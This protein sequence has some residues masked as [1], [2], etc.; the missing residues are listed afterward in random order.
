MASNRS[1]DWVDRAKELPIRFAQVREDPALDMQVARKAGREISVLLVASGG[2]T[3]CALATL[4]EV[5]ELTVVD[6]N[7]AQIALT[8]IK[9]QLLRECSKLERMQLL[10]HA[11]MNFVEREE[12][13]AQ[14]LDSQDLDLIGPTKNVARMGLDFTGRYEAV[15]REIASGME[16]VGDEL[17]SLLSL[18][19]IERQR[20]F[21]KETPK[22]RKALFETVHEVMGL[23]NLVA[24]FGEE[25]TRN[26]VQSFALHFYKR[27]IWAIEHLPAS[28]NPYLWQFLTSR[29]P[30]RD[31]ALWIDRKPSERWPEVQSHVCSIEEYLEN[32]NKQFDYIHLS[33]VLDWLSV[34]DASH[35]LRL[36]WNRLAPGGYTLIR[37][38][39][40]N[41]N[42]PRLGEPFTWLPYEAMALHQSDQSFFYRK[43]HL[44]RK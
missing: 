10:G 35:L 27:T 31:R 12:M 21:L 19:S 28:S 23:K 40:S 42:I 26:R 22:F 20:S 30:R 13:C 29:Y 41:L 2:C 14:R 24:L 4:S 17:T 34:A 25:A 3:A 8:L 11:P 43:M 7:R 37:Q 5:S 39:N 9:L 38:L 33:N 1:L 16:S 6:P 18:S 32:C 44:A 15:F 36:T